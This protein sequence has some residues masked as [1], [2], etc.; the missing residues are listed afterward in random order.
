MNCTDAPALICGHIDGELDADQNVQLTEHLEGCGACQATLS[1]LRSQDEQFRELIT[2]L[3]ADADALAERVLAELSPRGA[4]QRPPLWFGWFA[5]AA[6]IALLGSGFYIAE[7]TPGTSARV[8]MSLGPIAIDDHPANEPATSSPI[9]NGSTVVAHGRGCEFR[10]SGGATV[11]VRENSEARFDAPS[12]VELVSGR[13]YAATAENG[14]PLRLKVADT[15]V[16]ARSA[17]VD[18]E[19][20][21]TGT[22]VMVEQGAI[23]I[24]SG[25][26]PVHLNAGQIVSIDAGHVGVPRHVV[27]PIAETRWI[28]PFVAAREE[29]DSERRDRVTLVLAA[30]SG[31]PPQNCGGFGR[32]HEQLLVSP[33]NRIRQTEA[34]ADL[35]PGW[36]IPLLIDLLVDSV[37]DV[38]YHAARGLKRLTG[39][40]LGRPPQSWRD[41]GS[42]ACTTGDVPNWEAWW[43]ENQARFPSPA[44]PNP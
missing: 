12:A 37:P 42:I 20:I 38:R 40:D 23:T 19:H 41:L 21:D 15:V 9:H 25:K 27:D 16:I 28:T 34:L 3:R 8:V 33:E 43:A 7:Q 26:Q 11:R 32:D 30:L 5:A 24:E 39:E 44:G 14:R 1:D 36:R 31:T 6:S 18:I 10:L 17:R 35:A 2:P 22:M 29:M 13:L 4:A